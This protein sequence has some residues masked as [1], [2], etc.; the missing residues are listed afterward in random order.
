MT[1][2]LLSAQDLNLRQKHL[3]KQMLKVP[4]Y[5]QRM[6]EVEKEKIARYS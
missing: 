4:Y 6:Q 5:Y 1:G 3:V 2:L